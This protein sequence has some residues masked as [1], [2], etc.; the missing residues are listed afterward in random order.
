MWRSKTSWTRCR[1][2]WRDA[3]EAFRLWSR[4]WDDCARGSCADGLFRLGVGRGWILRVRGLDFNQI[5]RMNV[6]FGLKGNYKKN[7]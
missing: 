2:W 3:G 7:P 1:N 6:Q 4:L 5:G